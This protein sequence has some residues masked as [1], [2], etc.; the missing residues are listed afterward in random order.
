MIRTLSTKKS[1]VLD[2]ESLRLYLS[3]DLGI[4]GSGLEEYSLGKMIIRPDGHLD[5][6]E[7]SRNSSQCLP[8][9]SMP[10]HCWAQLLTRALQV[11][12][13][14]NELETIKDLKLVGPTI[15]CSS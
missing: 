9:L 11:S 14:L 13:Q 12:G 8:I 2:V 6:L 4:I 5:L 10:L 3:R 15:K 7:M 1:F